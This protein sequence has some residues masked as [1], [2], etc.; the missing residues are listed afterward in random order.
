MVSCHNKLC[1]AFAESCWRAHLGVQ[2]EMG[3]NVTSNHNHTHP[4]DLLVSNWVL[5]K[6]AAFD[7]LVTSPLDPMHNSL[8]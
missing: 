6:P 1:D 8:V 4:A 2:V 3:S 5:G 7:L